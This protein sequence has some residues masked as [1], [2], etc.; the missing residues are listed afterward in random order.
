MDIER[1]TVLQIVVATIG[2]LVFVAAAVYVASTYTVDGALTAQGGV[3]IVGAIGVFL[4]VMLA[5]G[6]WLERQDF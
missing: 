6:L 4:L 2:V 1:E 5:A 3:A